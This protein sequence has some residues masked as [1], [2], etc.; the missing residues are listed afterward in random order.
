MAIDGKKLYVIKFSDGSYYTG[1]NGTSK[2]LRQAKIYVS[3]KHLKEAVKRN[4]YEDY[5]VIEVDIKE[6]GEVYGN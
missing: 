2:Q 3:L 5:K 6:V 1:F 4:R